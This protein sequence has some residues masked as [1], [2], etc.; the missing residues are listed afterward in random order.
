MPL[1]AIQRIGL[2]YDS[3]KAIKR[4]IIL[5]HTSAFGTDGPYIDRVGFDGVGQ[6][7]SGSVWR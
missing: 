2:D 3:L 7:M 4:D 6:A 1:D 5:V